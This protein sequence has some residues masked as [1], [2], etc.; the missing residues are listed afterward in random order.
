MSSKFRTVT[1]AAAEDVRAP[2]HHASPIPAAVD[3]AAVAGHPGIMAARRRRR[4]PRHERDHA[5]GR[6][7]PHDPSVHLK[8]LWYA[9]LDGGDRYAPGSATNVSWEAL[10]QKKQVLP[11]DSSLAAAP[12][13]SMCI[14]HTGS[15]TVVVS[16][17]VASTGSLTSTTGVLGS[18]AGAACGIGVG[19]N[20]RRRLA[21]P[22]T[23]SEDKA[24]A[25]AAII[26]LS[27]S[28]NTG[29]ST[30]AA[31]GMPTVL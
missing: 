26:G 2:P 12:D 20:R 27:S 31:M 15:V 24:I 4:A 10:E 23:D 17:C 13:G 8:F 18:A 16:P 6:A 22:T 3:R 25:P 5:D 1:A 28:P 19:R 30:P 29:Y 21:L 9:C 7:K 11:S 14:P